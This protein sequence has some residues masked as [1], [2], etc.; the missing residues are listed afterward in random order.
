MHSSSSIHHK[1]SLNHHILQCRLPGSK[2]NVANLCLEVFQLL[3]H[4]GVLLGHLLVL[5]LPLVTVLLESLDFAFEMAGL[6]IGL[7][8]SMVVSLRVLY[9]SFRDAGEIHVLGNFH[10]LL[11]IGL[12]Q[13]LIGLLSFLLQELQSPLKSLV[14]CTM[15]T[16]LLSQRLRFL[17][18]SLQ[19]VNL[20]LE[21]SVLVREGCDFVFLL[22]VLLLECLDLLLKLFDLGSS[23]VGLDAQ[24]VHFL[25]PFSQYNSN[26]DKMRA[27]W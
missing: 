22:E 7:T 17:E 26:G 14:L 1:H 16:T 25:Q 3:L 20:S 9:N 13:V 6:D 2:S 18:L 5:C 21:P 23:L 8:E 19:L 24:R 15:L 27:V 10:N 11:V 4:S 12:S